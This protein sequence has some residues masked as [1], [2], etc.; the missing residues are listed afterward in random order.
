MLSPRIPRTVQK[1][2]PKA[3]EGDS[4]AHLRWLKTLPCVVCGQPADDPHHILGNVD[5]LPKGMGRKNEDRW[6]IPVCRKDHDLAHAH[7]NDEAWFASQGIDARSIAS[8]LW[9]VSGD[10]DAGQR[11]I[12]RAR[13]R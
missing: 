1:P 2:L 4:R 11:I 8:A 10:T 12:Y 13:T 5:G 3:R 7:G 9:R 6:A